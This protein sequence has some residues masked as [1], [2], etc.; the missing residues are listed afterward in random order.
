MT[1]HLSEAKAHLGQ[2]VARANA[3]ETITIC[4][5]NKPLAELGPTRLSLHPR[6]IKIGI[7][8]AKFAKVEL[9]D[10]FNA[11]FPE[12]EAAFYGHAQRKRKSRA[13]AA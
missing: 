9:P 13:S 5:G 11:P 3:G 4:E 12:F 6:I 7:L 2:Y 10:D 8:N 1:I